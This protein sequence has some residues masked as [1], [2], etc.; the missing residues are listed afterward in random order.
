MLTLDKA[1]LV[2]PD[3]QE[4]IASNNVITQRQSTLR[5]VANLEKP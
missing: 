2:E 3:L 1:G 4:A 5:R